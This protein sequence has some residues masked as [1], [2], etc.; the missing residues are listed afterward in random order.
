M[1]H[2]RQLER[3]EW[4]AG[5]DYV[6]ASDYDA[7]EARYRML[8]RWWLLSDGEGDVAPDDQDFDALDGQ[9]DDA[10]ARDL[11]GEPK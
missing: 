7:L 9:L 5:E 2:K 8:Q 4:R 6:L 10:I 1:N 11:K 3:Y